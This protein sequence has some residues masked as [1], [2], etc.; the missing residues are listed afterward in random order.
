MDVFI[1]HKCR[2]EHPFTR[3]MVHTI[4][5]GMFF[6]RKSVKAL[7]YNVVTSAVAWFVRCYVSIL[8]KRAC[9]QFRVPKISANTISGDGPVVLMF[10]HNRLLLMPHF[11]RYTCG[12]RGTAVVS[13]HRDG[14]Y[15]SKF[16]STYG[17][18]SIR[19]SSNHGG[20][21]ALRGAI[22]ALKN[23]KLLA[24]TPDGPTGPKYTVRG[25]IAAIVSK[26]NVP[27]LYA[28]YVAEKA[29]KFNTWDQFLLPNIF[30][31][32][33]IIIS[34]SDPIY[35]TSDFI[36]NLAAEN[37]TVNQWLEDAM[38]KQMICLEQEIRETASN[39][40]TLYKRRD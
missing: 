12:R 7:L 22:S 39:Y 20:H 28:C 17:H 6:C 36:A 38:N 16:L 32:Q 1:S 14:E 19:G 13:Q 8:L 25:N 29:K 31:K 15:I 10:W 26:Y 27:I 21:E 3:Y 34:V 33:K 30:L 35:C 37:C 24:V 2:V 9:V 5:V 11:V 40:I 4:S 18:D 23:G